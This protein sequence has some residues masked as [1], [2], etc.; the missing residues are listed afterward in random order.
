[1][2]HKSRNKALLKS[3][4]IPRRAA[5]RRKKI[6]R[7]SVARATH[8]GIQ[9]ARYCPLL[10]GF[11]VAANQG[12]E[13]RPLLTAN[14]SRTC[15]ASRN[16]RHESP[17]AALPAI[18]RYC[19]LLPALRSPQI[20]FPRKVSHSR[21]ASVFAKTVNRHPCR[22]RRQ[23]TDS[24]LTAARNCLLLLTT[25]C[26]CPLLPSKKLP[27]IK[28]PITA[29]HSRLASLMNWDKNVL[30]CGAGLAGLLESL[31]TVDGSPE[32]SLRWLRNCKDVVVKSLACI[33]PHVF[34]PA[35]S[36]KCTFRP[37]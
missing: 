35:D 31:G 5:V 2:N 27:R 26:Y 28:C 6:R 23:V 10:P 11:P 3:G 36:K 32:Q 37:L 25:A 9:V 30:A 21:W 7:R 22:A 16:T 33:S 14:L 17:D 13:S 24:L 15:R 1:M 20:K 29:G 8:H 19:P 34:R 18:A 12:Y 4:R